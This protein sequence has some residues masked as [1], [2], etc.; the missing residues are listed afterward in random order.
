[1]RLSIRPL[2]VLFIAMLLLAGCGK[3]TAQPAALVPLPRPVVTLDA[4]AGR[5]L[6]PAAALVERGGIPGV[7][8]LNAENQARFR[9]VRTGKHLNGRVEILSGLSGGETLVAGDL[10]EVHDGS[11]I[12]PP[13]MAEVPE[14]QEQFSGQ[15]K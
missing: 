15:K 2:S 3:K 7:F 10:R 5:V 11:P 14:T 8:V 9:M 4:Q 6:V 12:R 1:M 13:R